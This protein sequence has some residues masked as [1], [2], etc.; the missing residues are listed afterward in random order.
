MLLF[1]QAKINIGLQVLNKR[2][3]GYHNINTVFYPIPWEDAIEFHETPSFNLHCYGEDLNIPLS[4]HLLYKTWKLMQNEVEILK[5][6]EIT[7]HHL[8]HIPNG[9]GLGGGSGNVG[10]F[11]NAINDYFSCGLSQNTKENLAA[12]IGSDCAFFVHNQACL[13]KGRG[14]ILEP[15]DFSLSDYTIQIFNP[16]IKIATKNAFL[17]ISNNEKAKKEEL[18]LKDIIKLPVNEWKFYLE[19]SFSPWV[20]KEYPI[21]KESIEKL[22]KE[23]ALYAELSGSGPSFYAIFPK[24]KQLNK[25]LF[26]DM[27]SVII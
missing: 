13:G 11:I 14:D 26:K 4:E 10:A 24:N 6:K 16:K 12:N 20:Q 3:D 1:S 15:L 18:P 2:D 22:Y 27:R 21:I 23:G 8:K 9:A 19:N 5:S 17:S 7:I 25:F